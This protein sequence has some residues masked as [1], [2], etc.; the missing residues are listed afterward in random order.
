MANKTHISSLDGALE[1]AYD[2]VLVYDVVDGARATARGVRE[3][4]W[5]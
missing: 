3:G 2:L 1:R 4:G 5:G